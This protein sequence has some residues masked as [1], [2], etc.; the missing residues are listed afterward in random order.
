MNAEQLTRKLEL[1]DGR[2]VVV[3]R[4]GDDE[5]VIVPREHDG[6]LSIWAFSPAMDN[7]AGQLKMVEL[8]G[9]FRPGDLP[10]QPLESPLG[11]WASGAC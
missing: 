6:W 11:G 7:L 2:A 9:D 8:N 10:P 3:F 5:V 1:V 4:Q